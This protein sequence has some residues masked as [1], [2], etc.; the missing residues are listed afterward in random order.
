LI[1]DIERAKFKYE[2]A[3]NHVLAKEKSFGDI[4]R[5]RNITTNIRVMGD[6][7]TNG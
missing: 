6:L 7:L 1:Y 5:T 4:I 2:K 3:D